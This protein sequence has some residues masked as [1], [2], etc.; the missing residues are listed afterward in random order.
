[1][2]DLW[3]RVADLVFPAGQQYVH[4]PVR[5]AAERAGTPLWSRQRSI[6]ESV[7]DHPTTAVHSCH[8]IGKSFTGATTCCWWLDSHPP[9][10]AFVVTTAPTGPQ[11]KA[12]LWREINRIHQRVG[13]PGRTNLTEWYIDNEL[14]AFGRKPSEYEPTAFQG[15]HAEFVLVVLDEACGIPTSLWDAASTLTSNDTSRILAIGNPDDPHSHFA[16]VCKPNSGWNVIGVGAKDTP[17]FTGEQVPDIVRKSII[18]VSWAEQKAKDWGVTSPL[19]ISKVE[20]RFPV[21]SEDGVIR[22]SD[23]SKCR[24]MG[25]APV[26]GERVAGID[27]GAG[28]DRTV[29][30]PRVGNVFLEPRYVRKDDAEDTVDDLVAWIQELQLERVVIDVIGIGWGVYSRLKR[31]SSVHTPRGEG[32][33]GCVVQR[34]NA[35]EKVPAKKKDD[36]KFANRR[37]QMWWR[38]R[39]TLHSGA[40]DLAVIDDDTAAELVEPKFF[41]NKTGA[42]Q[43]EE[44]AEI[45]KRLGRSPDMADA[46]LMALEPGMPVAKSSGRSITKARIGEVA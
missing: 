27:V 39:T 14:V 8:N 13:L 38:G 31:L 21:D 18:S 11:V 9:G 41:I 26:E 40:V 36:L 28:G 3:D 2:T 20:G 45:I 7:R 44:K 1:M 16:K 34:F 32:K 42:V 4:D 5:W 35:A 30:Y 15:I 23:V 37:A 10:S 43:V 29:L 24:L 33:I 25:P 46:L 22:Y 19:Y 6:V 17:N 12:I